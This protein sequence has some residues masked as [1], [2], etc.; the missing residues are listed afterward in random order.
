MDLVLLTK[1]S[2]QV[3]KKVKRLGVSLFNT[4]NPE[5]SGQKKLCESLCNKKQKKPF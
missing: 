3:F 1:I 2:L 4:I 5:A